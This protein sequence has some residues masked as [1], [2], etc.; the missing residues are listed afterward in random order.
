M[1]IKGFCISEGI[2]RINHFLSERIRIHHVRLTEGFCFIE[3]EN[4]LTQL[5][6]TKVF[7]IKGGISKQI[8]A[9]VSDIL[10]IDGASNFRWDVQINREQ[11][12]TT[13]I[14]FWEETMPMSHLE[15]LVENLP[16]LD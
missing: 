15:T 8:P 14:V 9:G 4:L 1:N 16:A 13:F 2:A 5:N 6:V 11:R 12:V 7:I 3:Y 10:G